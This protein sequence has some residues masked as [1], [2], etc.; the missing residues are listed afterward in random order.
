VSRRRR[1][2]ESLGAGWIG[3]EALA[4]GL[5]LRS[6][7]PTTVSAS[8][9][10]GQPQRRQ[11]QHRLDV[12]GNLLGTM[13]GVEL[14]RTCSTTSAPDLIA[15]SADLA[16]R[17]STAN[18]VDPV[19][20]P[21]ALGSMRRTGKDMFG[22]GGDPDRGQTHGPSNSD[23]RHH[24]HRDCRRDHVPHRKDRGARS[25]TTALQEASRG[26]DTSRNVAGDGPQTRP[27]AQAQFVRRSTTVEELDHAGGRSGRVQHVVGAPT[28]G[29]TVD[30]TMTAEGAATYA[31]T[32]VACASSMSRSRTLTGSTALPRS[33]SKADSIPRSSSCTICRPARPV[34]VG[35]DG[36]TTSTSS[37]KPHRRADARLR[38]LLPV[39]AVVAEHLPAR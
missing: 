36:S 34:V 7:H 24:C 28:V 15:R 10:R 25:G 30:F 33:A 14:R 32:I 38:R 8:C 3:E 17:S 39:D 35:A 16:P 27:R 26:T 13:Y 4:I 31:M 21:V 18:P 29:D 1:R 2:V 23:H 19:P 12:A 22:T 37:S 11:R 9:F 5:Y 6:L 20:L